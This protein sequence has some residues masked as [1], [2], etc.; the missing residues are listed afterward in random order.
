MIEIINFF[1]I[2]GDMVAQWLVLV[3]LVTAITLLVVPIFTSARAN[4]Q[5]ALALIL[6]LVGGLWTGTQEVHHWTYNTHPHVM[7][8]C[9][10]LSV[11]SFKLRA[12]FFLE[13]EDYEI[14]YAFCFIYVMRI[15]IEAWGGLIGAEPVWIMTSMLLLLQVFL[16]WGGLFDGNGRLINNR[17]THLRCRAYVGFA[18]VKRLFH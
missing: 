7:V 9:G 4:V 5:C 14:N 6:S 11:F 10:F 15:V 18:S 1:T 3:V 2:E 12:P 16:A 8:A 13:M 17:L